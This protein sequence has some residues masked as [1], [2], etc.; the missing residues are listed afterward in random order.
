MRNGKRYLELQAKKTDKKVVV[1]VHPVVDEI[2]RH[3][4]TGGT[5][6]SSRPNHQSAFETTRE[7]A[8]IDDLIEVR[9]TE[10]GQTMTKFRCRPN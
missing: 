7:I 2:L 1:P 10:G 5:T 4:E 8:E 6:F 9:R 3:Y